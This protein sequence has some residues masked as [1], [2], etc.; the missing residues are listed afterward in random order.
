MI[1]FPA[2]PTVGQQFTAGGITW[3]WDGSKWTTSGS[4]GP[5]LQLAGGTLTGPLILA[6]NPV[7]PLGAST[8]QYVDSQPIIGSNRILN[9]D[10]LCAQYGS[11]GTLNGFTA[12]RWILGVTQTGK[13]NWQITASA[14]A[15]S[16]GFPRCMSITSLSAYTALATDSFCFY[17]TIEANMVND[18]AWGTSGAQ[19]VTLSFW[20]NVSIAGTYSGAISGFVSPQRS[21]AF[22]FNA[23][24]GW[25][26]QIINIPG[27]TIGTWVNSGNGGS[28][29]VTFDLGS[30]TNYRGIANQWQNA[31][32][33]GV[34]GTVNIV[35][36]NG[37][38]YQLTGVKLEIGS[39]ATPFN[40]ESISKSLSDCQRYYQTITSWLMGGYGAAGATL[41]SDTML[42]TGMRV[43]PTVTLVNPNY[44]NASGLTLNNSFVDSVALRMII[45]AAGTG[46]GQVTL[47]MSAEM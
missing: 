47:T 31:G 10:F 18:F 36:N 3:I 29:Y 46:W 39:I 42:A 34:N 43:A 13:L 15:T 33:N 14:A 23:P 9:G 40:R 30:G 32:L 28:F 8:K 22:T 35:A 7:V 27:D 38:V 37:A 2:S 25:S 4:G 45:T 20:I 41:Y 1:D 11:S 12:D 5:Y 24:V 26:K 16:L 17:Q 44:S 6:S 21:Y 19:P